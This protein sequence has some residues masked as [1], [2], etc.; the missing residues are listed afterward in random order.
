MD[1]SIVDD[2]CA[3]S[4]SSSSSNRAKRVNPSPLIPGID[5]Y[6]DSTLLFFFHFRPVSIRLNK[7]SGKTSL[8]LPEKESMR[9][10]ERAEKER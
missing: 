3:V 5:H 7:I 6:D 10:K 9:D 2:C 4:F 8:Y 1:P